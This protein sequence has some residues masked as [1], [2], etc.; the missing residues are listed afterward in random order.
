MHTYKV[1]STPI[2]CTD[3]KALFNEQ[4]FKIIKMKSARELAP[5]A[6]SSAWDLLLYYDYDYVA[7]E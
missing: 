4:S 6:N 3:D 7:M 2:L 1:S 5:Y